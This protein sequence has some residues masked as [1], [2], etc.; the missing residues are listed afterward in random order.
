MK[1]RRIGTIVLL[2]LCVVVLVSFVRVYFKD[3]ELRREIDRVRRDV[4]SLEK[5]K[6]ESLELLKK[7]QSDAYVEERARVELQRG[8]ADEA[9]LVV[10]GQVVS[11]TDAQRLAPPTERRELSNPRKWW[12][13]FFRPNAGVI[14]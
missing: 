3:Y 6:I 10:P 12:Y 2:A 9:V 14:N 7:L 4:S 5:R 11:S 1:S 8:R 13:Y